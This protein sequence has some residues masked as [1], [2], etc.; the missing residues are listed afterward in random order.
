MRSSRRHRRLVAA[1]VV[2][3]YAVATV[4]AR[5]RGYLVGGNVVVRCRRGHLFTTIWVPG[6]TVKAVKLGWWRLQWCPVGRHIS[7]VSP[8]RD[9]ELT[10]EQRRS[11]GRHRDVRIP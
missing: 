7:L 4:V 2:V 5:R 8:V 10:D 6:V 1:F 9:S 11:A 3:F